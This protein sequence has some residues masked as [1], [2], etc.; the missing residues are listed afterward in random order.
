MGANAEIARRWFREVWVEGGEATV[1]ALL[2]PNAV[3]QM[4]GRGVTGIAEFKAERRSL[5]QVFPDMSL[6][7]EDLVEEG[8]KVAVRW[9]VD[10]TH[11]GDGLGMPATKR[12]VSF[13]GTTWLEIRGGKIVHGWDHWNLGGLIASLKEA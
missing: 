8:N 10:A 1:D 12:P 2:D 13:N 3:G 6:S 4:E 9:K 7:I 5:L 11:L